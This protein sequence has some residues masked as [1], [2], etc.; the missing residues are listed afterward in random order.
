MRSGSRQGKDYR[1]VPL[2]TAYRPVS[3]TDWIVVAKLD[4]DEVLAPLRELAFWV[5]LITLLAIATVGI[6][7]F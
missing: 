2:F 1:G 4:R 5:S 3:G 7:Y 6:E